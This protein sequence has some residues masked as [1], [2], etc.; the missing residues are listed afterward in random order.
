LFLAADN[1]K[2][3]PRLVQ[4]GDACCCRYAAI[5][6]NRLWTEFSCWE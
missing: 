3:T 6:D 1:I 5:T 4:N 2:T